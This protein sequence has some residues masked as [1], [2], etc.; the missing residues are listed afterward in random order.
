MNKKPKEDRKKKIRKSKGAGIV[1]GISET[2]S[3]QKILD[4]S[5]K[6]FTDFGFEGA[7][8]DR[9]ARNAGINKAMI[10]YYFSSKENLY[11]TVI[12]DV[13]LDFVPRVLK[14][15]QESS[16]PE[17][18]FE[19]LPALYIRYFSQKKDILKMIAREMIHAPRNIT[20]L[21]REIFAQLPGLPSQI[22]PRVIR[23]WHG[24][25]WISESDPV[26]FIF[27]I[28]PLC[29]FPLIAQPMVEAIFDVRIADDRDFLDKRIR[30]IT[31]LLKRGMLL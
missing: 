5:L 18:L 8:V 21:I 25:G 23:D 24:Q 2:T 16:T 11:R 30:S 26:H 14:L 28:I 22:L 12:K 3:R 10:F 9:I 6:E 29:L 15:V 31:H 27:N 19:T 1:G 13:M 20:P 7:R 17:R 4:A